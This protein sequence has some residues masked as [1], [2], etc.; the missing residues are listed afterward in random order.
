ML[1][2]TA[3]EPDG[4]VSLR[5]CLDQWREP[6]S[7]WPLPD[8]S[9]PPA[10]LPAEL[11]PPPKTIALFGMAL[12]IRMEP[13]P[14]EGP[15]AVDAHAVGGIDRQTG[16]QATPPLQRDPYFLAIRKQKLHSFSRGH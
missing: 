8:I 7:D 1:A 13:V 11:S 12:V 9:Q 15:F 6:D 4:R 2:R 3:N 10:V 14:I 5:W 16:E